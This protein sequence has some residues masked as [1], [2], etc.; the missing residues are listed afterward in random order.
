M[1]KGLIALGALAVVVFLRKSAAAAPAPAPGFVAEAT[2]ELPVK[3]TGASYAR[4]NLGGRFMF[5]DVA[6]GNEITQA[7]AARRAITEGQALPT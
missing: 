7:E 5:I 3:V 6:T 1:N 2:P 4:I